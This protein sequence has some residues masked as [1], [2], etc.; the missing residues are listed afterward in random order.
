[1]LTVARKMNEEARQKNKRP[2]A[3]AKGKKPS[4]S[5]ENTTLKAVSNKR[6]GATQSRD[7]APDKKVESGIE[8]TKIPSGNGG[9]GKNY[10]WH[11]TLS[12]LTVFAKLRKETPSK[13]IACRIQP[14]HLSIGIKGESPIIEGEI[15]E[16]WSVNPTESFWTWEKDKGILTVSLDKKEETWWPSVVVGEPEIDTQLVDSTRH[17]SEYDD[18]T[19]ATIRKIVH[20][21]NQKRS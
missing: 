4:S 1:M 2:E 18:K 13:E 20:D 9:F 14:R 7:P 10:E 8:S 11:Q 3:T 19:Q 6:S 17:I 15:P 21:Q 5:R 12:D 16:S